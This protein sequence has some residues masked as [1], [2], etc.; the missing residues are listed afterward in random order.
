MN[1]RWFEE[2]WFLEVGGRDSTDL[3]KALRSLRRSRDRLNSCCA[4]WTPASSC[5]YCTFSACRV[6]SSCRLWRLWALAREHS[7]IDMKYQQID[8]NK[9]AHIGLIGNWKQYSNGL[10]S[11]LIFTNTSFIVSFSSW[12][13]V[14]IGHARL[15]WK[16]WRYAGSSDKSYKV[17]SS[18]VFTI[19]INSVALH[20]AFRGVICIYY[21]NIF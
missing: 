9:L 11:V 2:E 10:I 15:V 7:K 19:Y 14:E 3:L 21:I 6:R 18:Y 13:R 4:P 20:L 16:R 8:L 5:W 12:Q 1:N 17:E